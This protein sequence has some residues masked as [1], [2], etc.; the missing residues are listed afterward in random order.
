MQLIKHLKIRESEVL[1]VD[2]ETTSFQEEK[3][4]LSRCNLKGATSG[5]ECNF[6]LLQLGPLKLH[7]AIS[8]DD[9]CSQ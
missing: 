2:V 7:F 1:L 5:T 3:Y 8:D 6:S 4:L 9:S